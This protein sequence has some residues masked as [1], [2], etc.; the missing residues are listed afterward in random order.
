MPGRSDYL[1]LNLRVQYELPLDV[2][3]RRL[4]FYWELYNLT[5]RNNFSNVQT[6]LTNASFGKFT[7]AGPGRSIQ[8]GI[9]FGF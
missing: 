3:S 4:G 7:S 1:T 8:L 9:K 5:N 2:A 6:V